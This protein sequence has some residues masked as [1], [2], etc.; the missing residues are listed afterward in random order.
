MISGP[1]TSRVHESS[2]V[3]VMHALR[4]EMLENKPAMLPAEFRRRYGLEPAGTEVLS[5]S[6]M[7]RAEL[8]RWS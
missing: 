6:T 4:K 3:E 7:R 8:G 2:F 5:V 1:S